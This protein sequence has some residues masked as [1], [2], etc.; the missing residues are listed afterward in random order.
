MYPLPRPRHAC[1]R[2]GSSFLERCAA[3]RSLVRPGEVYTH[4]A[5]ASR[6]AQHCH[7][8]RTEGVACY[9]R[10]LDISYTG[11]EPADN[12]CSPAT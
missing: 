10:R 5:A 2:V 12:W 11:D 4:A 8:S 6:H 7:D 3:L 1:A 9:L